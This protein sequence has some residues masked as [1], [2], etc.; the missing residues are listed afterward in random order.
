M[1]FRKNNITKKKYTRISRSKSCIKRKNKFIISYKRK[2][3][4]RKSNKRKSNKAKIL[5]GAGW[6]SSTETAEKEKISYKDGFFNYFTFPFVYIYDTS[7]VKLRYCQLNY[8]KK[9]EPLEIPSMQEVSIVTGKNYLDNIKLSDMFNGLNNI[10]LKLKKPDDKT[11]KFRLIFYKDKSMVIDNVDTRWRG[12]CGRPYCLKNAYIGNAIKFL[13]GG[14]QGI[15]TDYEKYIAIFNKNKKTCL[16]RSK[17]YHNNYLNGGNNI[18]EAWNNVFTVPDIESEIYK[19]KLPF[20]ATK[21]NNF[22]HIFL[23][24]NSNKTVIQILITETVYKFGEEIPR[25]FYEIKLETSTEASPPVNP[26]LISN[27]RGVRLTHEPKSK[28]PPVNPL[29]I[30]NERGVRLTHE[31]KSKTPPVNP[32][33]LVNNR[34]VLLLGENEKASS[35]FTTETTTA[36]SAAAATTATTGTMDS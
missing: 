36:P 21:L 32:L 12:K 13:K 4:K 20:I 10:V 33:L 18:I 35:T 19:I 5:I 14:L 3:N 23:I 6:F 2:P 17:Q 7:D 31:P 16:Y 11:I 24:K 15:R 30:S 9:N 26:L 22:V 8:L 29:L 34:G 28:T 1:T 27:E 25:S